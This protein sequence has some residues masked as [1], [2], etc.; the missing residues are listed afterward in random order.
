MK[1]E[2]KEVKRNHLRELFRGLCLFILFFSF[3]FSVINS[4]T[5]QSG[6]YVPSAKPVKDMKKALTN[7]PTFSLLLT[8]R[9]VDTAYSVDDLDLLDSAFN[10]AFDIE[11]PNYYTMSVEGYA[12]GTDD[13]LGWTRVMSVVKYFGNRCHSRVPIRMARN[14]IRCSCHGDSVE[15]IRFE[16]PLATEVYDY[17][18]FALEFFEQGRGDSRHYSAAMCAL[19]RA[20][21]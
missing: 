15:T 2:M 10:I 21:G 5:A 9:G 20:A 17:E 13:S 16:V 12:S 1:N 4:A 6:L 19:C 18:T 14:P 7:P 11:N 8:Y 3:Q